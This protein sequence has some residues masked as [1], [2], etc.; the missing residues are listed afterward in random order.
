MTPADRELLEKLARLACDAGALE[1]EWRNAAHKFFAI[2]RARELQF[3]K[4]YK[5]VEPAKAPQV[6]VGIPNDFWEDPRKQ[7]E[8][9]AGQAE[10]AARKWKQQNMYQ[11][12]EDAKKREEARKREEEKFNEEFEY[13]KARS[14]WQVE[15]WWESAV[16]PFGK[17]KGKTVGWIYDHELEYLYWLYAHNDLY[18]YFGECVKAAIGQSFEEEKR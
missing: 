10:E 8:R 1:G 11:A 7:T 13:A 5:E 14:S 3:S 9:A 17:Y 12:A 2:L 4:V 18:G 15:E 6:H 16:V